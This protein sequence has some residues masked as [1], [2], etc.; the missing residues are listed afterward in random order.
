MAGTMAKR[1]WGSLYKRDKQWY[2]RVRIG[3]RRTTRLLQDED[4]QP[5]TTHKEAERALERLRIQ[6]EEEEAILRGKRARLGEWLDLEYS[7]ILR[8][9]LTGHGADQAEQYLVRFA[10]WAGNPF[11]DEVSRGDVERY[12][13]HFVAPKDEHGLGHKASYLRRVVNVLRRAWR[14]AATRG[15]VRENP[16]SKA[17]VPRIEET[18]VPWVEPELLHKLCDE[19]TPFQRPLVTLLAETGLRVGEALALPRH[20]VDLRSK[21]LHVRRGKTRAAKRS[22]PLT[23]RALEAVRQLPERDD[24][25]L[26]EPRAPYATLM[27]LQRACRTLKVEELT[28]HQLRHVYASHL[29]QSGCPPTVV[30]ALL[31]HADGG[32]L[33]LRLYGRWYPQ[34]AQS[35]AVAAMTA[36]RSSRGSDAGSRATRV[37]RRDPGV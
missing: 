16:W 36:F 21:V 29:V 22:I 23:P 12:C 27:G 26:F 11:M 13:A 37:R 8:A 28:L 31:G 18:V 3:G 5:C 32:A 25:L 34:D 7:G 6:L 17:P 20:D 35:R 15:F 2:A 10:K 1:S 4:D 9:R 19:M 24:G 14:D 33:V 30:A